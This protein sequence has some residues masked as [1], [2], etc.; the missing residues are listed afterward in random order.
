[1]ARFWYAYWFRP[2][3]SVNL[4]MA[5]IVIVGMQL[6]L[7]ALREVYNYNR[8]IELASLPEILYKPLPIFRFLTFPFGSDFRPSLDIV[9]VIYGLA[10]VFGLLALIGYKTKI[11]LA[12]FAFSIL[13]LQA[14]SYSFGEK[15]HAE[16]IY[17][18]VI[19]ML[20]LS[21]SGKVLSLDALLRQRRLNPKRVWHGFFNV[22]DERDS[23]ARW[24][25]LMA[26]WM[27]AL[28][29]LDSAVSKLSGAGFDWVNGYTLQ[30]YLVRDGT[31][32]GSEFAT[33]L[34]EHHVLTML[35]SWQTLIFQGTFFLVL[36]FPKLARVYAPL[37]LSLHAGMCVTHIACFWQFMALYV[38]FIPWVSLFRALSRHPL[39]LAASRRTQQANSSAA[40]R[41]VT[42]STQGQETDEAR[43]NCRTSDNI[44]RWFMRPVQPVR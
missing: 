44:L 3:L 26:Q 21:P 32:R 1:M 39:F 42:E 37:A 43:F 11:S 4:A 10:F 31:L 22:M 34:S 13:F 20:A 27:L 18:M 35:L 9:L 16:G 14:F 17:I 8:Y 36:I 5:R 6:L 12:L 30:F 23:F 15:H 40:R 41:A 28:A 2:S 7:L 24:P 33:W 38:V 29:Y 19:F 25:L